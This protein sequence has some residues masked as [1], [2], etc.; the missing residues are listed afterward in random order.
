M[1]CP[2]YEESQPC[3]DLTGRGSCG[4]STQCEVYPLIISTIATQASD[5]RYLHASPKAGFT[6]GTLG[7]A[8]LARI[9][10]HVV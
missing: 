1:F 9:S 4:K 10:W 3:A 2:I 8:R 7:F 6:D 5:Q